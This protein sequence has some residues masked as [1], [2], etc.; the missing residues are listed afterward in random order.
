[1]RNVMTGFEP[2]SRHPRFK[3]GRRVRVPL[4]EGSNGVLYLSW[5]KSCAHYYRTEGREGMVSSPLKGFL[6]SDR[7]GAAVSN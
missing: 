2:A 7:G 5:K 4:E 1:M 6:C 3:R